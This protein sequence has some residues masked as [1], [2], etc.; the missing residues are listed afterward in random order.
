MTE[1]VV[2][3]ALEATREELQEVDREKHLIKAVK[4]RE[5]VE[6]SVDE[7]E[8][9]FRDW[10]SLHFPELVEEIDGIEDLVKILDSEVERSSI[11]SFEQLASGSTGS[12]LADEE[13]EILKSVVENLGSD[14]ELR[15]RLDDYIAELAKQEMPS[16]SKLLGTFLAAK[17]IALSGG[18]EEMAKKPAS[19]VQ[20][21]GA[22]KA[23]FRY[24]RGEGTPPKHGILFEHEFVRPLA[25]NRGKMAR[26]MAN[27]AVMAARLD[28]YSGKDEGERLREEARKK[29]EELKGE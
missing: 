21:L 15:K 22:E 6:A 8:E 28:N 4:M 1:D 25:D 19:T 14:L 13:A 18:L 10:Y 27:K 12:E 26:F 2:E 9:R 29:F 7:K 3:E 23:L 17:M 5:K 11:D 16:L 24:L 20:M